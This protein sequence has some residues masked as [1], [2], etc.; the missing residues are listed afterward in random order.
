MPDMAA[1]KPP[2]KETDVIYAIERQFYRP[3]I[4]WLFVEAPDLE[5]ACRIAEQHDDWY[6]AE[7]IGDC[8]TET[9]ISR[10]LE[11]PDGHEDRDGLSFEN[12]VA[13]KMSPPGSSVCSVARYVLYHDGPSLAIPD[14]Y[15]EKMVLGGF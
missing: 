12:G 5:T 4:Q 15:A 13:T 8:S 9:A 1:I 10:A 14:K 2:G 3:T 11:L 6:D 7:E